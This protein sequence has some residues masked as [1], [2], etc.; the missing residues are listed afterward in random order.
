MCVLVFQG[1]PSFPLLF[2][3]VLCPPI[4]H[5]VAPPSPVPLTTKTAGLGV[6]PTAGQKPCYACAPQAQG[7]LVPAGPLKS[8]S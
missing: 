7:G 2:F 1:L 4:A 8:Q 3:S 5:S 6:G